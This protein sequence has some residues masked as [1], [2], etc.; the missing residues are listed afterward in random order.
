MRTL[1]SVLIIL[2]SCCSV[3]Y[4]QADNS[5][6]TLPSGKQIK[7]T[8][9]IPMHFPK[10]PDALILNCE[11]DIPMSDMVAL[12]KEVDEIWATFFQK[13]VERANMTGGVIR[14]SHPEGTGLITRADGYG[15][16]FEKRADG[17]WHCANDD[18]K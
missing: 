17:Q 2:G 16:L 10:G 3:C 1:V 6:K 18:K 15:F 8:S 13:E 5:I 12:R 9:I 11:T 14:I 4:G 7:I